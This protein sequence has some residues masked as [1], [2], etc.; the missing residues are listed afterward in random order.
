MSDCK[1]E[2]REEPRVLSWEGSEPL[3]TI[4]DKNFA[5]FLLEKIAKVAEERSDAVAMVGILSVCIY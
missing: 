5:V 3:P 2:L 4:P 1:K